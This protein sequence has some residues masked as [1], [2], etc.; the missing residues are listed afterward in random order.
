MVQRCDVIVR[1]TTQGERVISAARDGNRKVGAM[2]F[3]ATDGAPIRSSEFVISLK[4]RDRTL[5]GDSE[6]V[7]LVMTSKLFLP[8]N[9]CQGKLAPVLIHFVAEIQ[10]GARRQI[11][12]ILA[13]LAPTGY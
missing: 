6:V 3:R 8:P 11:D 1:D 4:L 7:D 13:K 10:L 12:K 2:A 5:P 9:A